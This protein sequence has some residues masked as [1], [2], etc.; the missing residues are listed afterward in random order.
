MNTECKLLDF[1]PVVVSSA[2]I[3][4]DMDSV[5]MTVIDDSSFSAKVLLQEGGTSAPTLLA[6]FS[7][8]YYSTAGW[9][10]V[11]ISKPERSC[12]SSVIK[13][14]RAEIDDPQIAFVMKEYAGWKQRVDLRTGASKEPDVHTS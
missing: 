14:I 8:C 12:E 2:V 9:D 3:G 1:E 6:S 5:R 11:P 4:E 13:F 10:E 7:A